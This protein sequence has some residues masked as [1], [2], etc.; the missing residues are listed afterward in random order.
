MLTENLK[1]NKTIIIT[2]NNT[3]FKIN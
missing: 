3:Y 2:I 1:I